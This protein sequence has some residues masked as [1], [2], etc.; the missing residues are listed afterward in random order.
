[1][2]LPR[3]TP[4]A[5]RQWGQTA[6]ILMLPFFSFLALPGSAALLPGVD[7]GFAASTREMLARGDFLTASVD[8]VAH[9][10][11]PLLLHWLQ[12]LALQLSTS[13]AALRLPSALAA[14][15]GC[16]LAG[17]FVRPRGGGQAAAATVILA[18]TALGSLLHARLAT[19]DALFHLLLALTLFDSWRHL[20]NGAR[21]PLLRSYLWIALGLLARGPAALLLPATITLLYCASRREW[22]PWL[23][24]Y[25]DRRGWLLLA[26]LL[27]PFTLT[28]LILHGSAFIDGVL[29]QHEPFTAPLAQRAGAM[30]QAV[31]LLP[32]LMLPWT[33]PLLASVGEIRADRDIGVRRFLWI[34]AGCGALLLP[35]AGAPVLQGA[36]A[37]LLPL[38]M[39]IALRR[40]QLEAQEGA[41]DERGLAA[42]TLLFALCVMLPFVAHMLSLTDIGSIDDRIRLG[43]ALEVADLGYYA[44]C[45]GALLLWL[46]IML[47]SSAGTG[48]RLFYA[49]LIQV[50]L[51][52]TTVLPWVATVMQ[53]PI[54]TLPAP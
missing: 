10:G 30:L 45:L 4:A 15:L 23:R 7:A 52:H 51:L 21:A 16:L 14:V 9:P 47:R 3:P 31:L 12:A 25:L 8:G 29:A 48:V 17:L 5:R 54:D 26:L 22:T 39:L 20:E 44:R 38:C 46:A 13:D 37:A 11:A 24:L 28:A 33:K 49:A 34:W 42:P 41:A 43:A 6:L 40:E 1:M 53:E 32:V 18:A 36:G 19:V 50:L 27:L 35:L 2:P